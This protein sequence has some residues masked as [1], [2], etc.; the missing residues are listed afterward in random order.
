MTT[1]IFALI[2]LPECA[3]F[4]RFEGKNWQVEKI[5]GESWSPLPQLE[6]VTPLLQSLDKRVNDG[7]LAHVSLDVLY[8]E[9]AISALPGLAATLAELQCLQWQILRLAPLRQRAI[10][11]SGKPAKDPW[12][13]EWLCKSMLPVLQAST[14]YSDEAL[15][16]EHQRAEQEHEETLDTLR[17]ERSQLEAQLAELQAQIHA[18]QLP[19]ITHLLTYLPALYRNVWGCIGPHELALLA[20]QLHI[21]EIPSPFPEPSAD[22][23]AALQRRLFKLPREERQRLHAFCHELPHKLNPRTEMRAWLEGDAP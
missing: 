12:A 20:G 21:P 11:L 4:F 6:A 19:D 18:V 5:N 2:L 17:A 14:R 13:I 9:N 16:Q 8:D 3:A 10:V 1:K 23:L 22:T 7:N 15:Q